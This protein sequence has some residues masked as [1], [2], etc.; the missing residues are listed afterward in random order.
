MLR[1][2]VLLLAAYVVFHKVFPFSAMGRRLADITIGEF[3]LTIFQVLLA[4]TI[5]GYLIIQGF[6]YGALQDRDRVWCERWSGLAFG[7]TAIIMA[8]I[9]VA[10]LERRGFQFGGAHWIAYGVLSL[11][12]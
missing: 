12:F 8:S 11:L 5:A 3:L 2:L 7:L 9:S 10:I 6:R 4:T 1:W